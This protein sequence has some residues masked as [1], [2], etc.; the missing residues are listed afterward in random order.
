MSIAIER[1]L[2]QGLA[3]AAVATG[4]SAQ[5]AQEVQERAGVGEA[6]RAAAGTDRITREE[7]TTIAVRL[8]H[9]IMIPLKDDSGTVRAFLS[10][11]EG[12]G[13]TTPVTITDPQGV[14]IGEIGRPMVGGMNMEDTHTDLFGMSGELAKLRKRVGELEA[15][16]NG[17]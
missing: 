17:R 10:Y 2:F 7:A 13:Q 6:I 4:A 12:D 5:V 15:K 1:F 9:K 14:V 11:T 8:P 3:A 16:V